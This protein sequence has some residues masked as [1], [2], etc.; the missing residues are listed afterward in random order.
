ML[1]RK[2]FLMKVNT[3]RQMINF[4]ILITSK[5]QRIKVRGKN[6]YIRVLKFPN[7]KVLSKK[8]NNRE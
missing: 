1:L 6:N 3:F 7:F 5:V 8:S 4:L 2:I